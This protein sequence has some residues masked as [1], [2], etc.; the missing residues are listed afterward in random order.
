MNRVFKMTE[1]NDKRNIDDDGYGDKNPVKQKPEDNQPDYPHSEQLPSDANY[2]RTDL[3]NPNKKN[4]TIP[5]LNR[6]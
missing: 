3:D 1:N 5:F 4:T 6:G 2:E